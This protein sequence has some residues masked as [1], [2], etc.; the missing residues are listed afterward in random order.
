MLSTTTART[1]HEAAVSAARHRAASAALI[2]ILSNCTLQ[3][4]QIRESAAAGVCIRFVHSGLGQATISSA[5]NLRP[6]QGQP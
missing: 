6:G 3:F 4:A 1:S 5:S 2:C